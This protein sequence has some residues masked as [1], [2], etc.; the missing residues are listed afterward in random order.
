MPFNPIE[1]G[2]IASLGRVVE[3]A[4][5]IKGYAETLVSGLRDCFAAQSPQLRWG[6]SFQ[7]QADNATA[8]IDSV[9]GKA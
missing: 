5:E 4:N 1:P 3:T 9:F 7:V 6:V 8:I 2:K